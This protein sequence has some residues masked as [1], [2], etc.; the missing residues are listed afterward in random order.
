MCRDILGLPE[1]LR[2]F[3][4]LTSRGGAYG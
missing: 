3:T 4:Q 1:Y 2:L